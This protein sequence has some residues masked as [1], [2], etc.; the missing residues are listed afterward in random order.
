MSTIKV[1]K[2]QGTSGSTTGLTFSGANGTFGG[3][4]AVTGAV[5][6]SDDM[7]FNSGYGSAATAY[8]CRAW[9]NFN[10]TGTVAIRES[11]NVS[12]LT[13][14]GTG[15]YTG[16]FASAIVDANYSLACSAV[17]SVGY[18]VQFTAT[19]KANT[20]FST[21]SVGIVTGNTSSANYADS[22]TVSATITR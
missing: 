7:N 8:G 10:G 17:G 6:A 9:V 13:D 15:D 3:T 22:A 19:P 16:N 12:S 2:L 21:T 4:L 11:G 18:Q 14:N 20:S 1:D 5:T